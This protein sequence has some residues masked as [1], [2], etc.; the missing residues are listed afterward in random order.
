M[1]T[2]VLPIPIFLNEKE[3]RE[4][5]IRNVNAGI[6]ADANRFI[7]KGDSYRGIQ[8][9]IAGCTERIGDITDK[10]AIFSMIGF[11][12]FKSASWVSIQIIFL[13]EKDDGVEGMYPCPRCGEKKICEF[14]E[15]EN[16][17]TRDYL[18]DLPLKVMK[19]KKSTFEI[20]LKKSIFIKDQDQ[21]SEEVKSLEIYYPTLNHCSMAL[22]KIGDKDHVRLQLQIYIQALKSVNDQ[23]IDNRYKNNFGSFIFESI[24][25]E[26]IKQIGDL[27]DQFGL[28]T[29]IKKVCTACGKEW[30]VNINTSNFFVS[31]LR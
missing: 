8:T 29:G 31:A 20:E 9:F 17:D 12:P 21:G 27:V 6:I 7:Q 25:S 28:E 18:K 4:I 3:Y 5:E 16:L 15:D 23:E 26:D 13:D 10:Q 2:I 11:M 24:G 19:D 30:V 1:G 14:N 22:N